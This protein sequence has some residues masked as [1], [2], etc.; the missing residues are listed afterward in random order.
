VPLDGRRRIPDAARYSNRWAKGIYLTCLAQVASARIGPRRTKR[1]AR[2]RCV[3][4]VSCL[5]GDGAAQLAEVG[6]G[7]AGGPFAGAEYDGA[8][9]LGS[10]ID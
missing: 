4:V 6:V 7:G 8:V 9:G 10:L 3:V 1:S 5:T 2:P